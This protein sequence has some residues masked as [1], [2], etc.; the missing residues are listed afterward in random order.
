MPIGYKF[1]KSICLS[2]SSVLISASLVGLPLITRAA[3][4]TSS[5]DTT[6]ANSVN[7]NTGNINNTSN[8]AVTNT[9]TTNNSI[10]FYINTGNNK[11]SNNTTVGN[12]ATGN[13]TPKISID[14]NLNTEKITIPSNSSDPTISSTNHLTGAGSTNQNTTNIS[15]LS[16]ITITQLANIRNNVSECLNTG[17]NT[18]SNNTKIGD[19]STGNINSIITIN[20]TANGPSDGKGGGNTPP[21]ANGGGSGITNA[22]AIVTPAHIIPAS[23]TFFP[24]GGSSTAPL[25]AILGLLALALAP[26]AKRKITQL[27]EG[28]PT[29]GNGLVPSSFN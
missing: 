2:V 23:A 1:V 19:I 28:R 16:K 7:A 11:V 8:T 10:D 12:V 27:F 29:H 17:G 13:I 3:D 24:S 6:G 20:N 22:L 9:A 4:I 14:N 26:V 5:N 21:P 25:I 18:F 15:T